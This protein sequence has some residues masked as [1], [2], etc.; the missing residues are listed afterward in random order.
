MNNTLYTIDEFNEFVE[1]DLNGLVNEI[2]E[3]V[4]GR[5]PSLSERQA[6]ICSYKV[7]SEML[8]CAVEKNPELAKAHIGISMVKFEY[9]LPSAPAW[10]DLVILGEADNKK[11]AIIVELKDWYR[12]ET[13][14]PGICEGVVEHRGNTIQHPSDQVKGYV[15]YCQSFH[16]AVNE[17]KAEVSGCVFFTRRMNLTPYLSHPNENLTS[18]YPMYNTDTLDGL[19]DYVSSRVSKGNEDWAV[20]FLNG[21]YEQNRNILKQV[22][23]AFSHHK[24]ARPFVLLNEQRV[25]YA[26]VFHFL[27][28]AVE[29]EDE[30]RV[31]IVSGPPGSGKSAIALNIWADAVQ[32]YVANDTGKHPGNVVFVATSSSQNDNWESV[33]NEYAGNSAAE[34]LVMRSNDFNPGMTGITMRNIYLPIFKSKGSHYVREDNKNSLKYEYFREYLQYMIDKN[35]TRGYKDNLHFLS[36]IDEAHALI[37]PLAPN[38]CTNSLGGWCMQMGPQAYHIIRESR[39]S[40]FFMDGEQSFRDNETTT[41]NHIELW[42]NELGAKVDKIDLAGLQFRCAG[43][44]EYVDWVDRLFTPHSANNVDLWR[45]HFKVEVYDTT[46]E[47]EKQLQG[48][49]QSGKCVRLLSSCTVPW[50]S[51]R[52]LDEMHTR[53]ELDCDFDF[54]NED[55]VPFKRHWNNP[56]RMD[57]FVQAPPFT[58]MHEDPLCEVGCPYEIRGFDV[59]YV[60]LLCLGDIVWRGDK[61]MIDLTKTVDRANKS[62]LSQA[63]KELINY[64][65]GLGMSRREAEKIPLIPVNIDE[66]MFPK[67]TILIKTVLQAYRILMTRAVRGVYLYI[68]DKE[69]REHIR[70]LLNA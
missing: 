69:T 19:A 4:S 12:N 23:E 40:V 35:L 21:Y 39:V 64:R 63:R 48:L 32:K 55:G 25:G 37:N 41:Q 2:C 3:N 28:Q 26:K 62:S 70:K 36:I 16:S 1:D 33:F 45:D 9:K 6:M 51:D 53:G 29:N 50:I 66:C 34:G 30:K 46:H 27:S 13:D 22:S 52:S 56:Q 68:H 20:R 14:A 15:Q 65:R 58:K 10:C 31:I 67:T 49:H 60:G 17:E 57:I 54:M 42:A 47:M 44:V 5:K 59:D 8:A 43:S 61:W 24:D 11:K 38:F 7:V 18:D